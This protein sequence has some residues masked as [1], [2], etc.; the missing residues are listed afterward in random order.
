MEERKVIV[1]TAGTTVQHTITH[2]GKAWVFTTA[3]GNEAEYSTIS[4]MMQRHNGVDWNSSV[5]AHVED[6]AKP[7]SIDMRP[8]PLIERF[9]HSLGSYG[10]AQWWMEGE[11]VSFA[12]IKT[13]LQ[14]VLAENVALKAQQPKAPVR[15]LRE[16]KGV[17]YLDGFWVDADGCKWEGASGVIWNN[18]LRNPRQK[19]GELTDADFLAIYALKD[20]PYEPVETVEEVLR[21]MYGLFGVSMI[22]MPKYHEDVITR[23]RAAFAAE[24]G[25]AE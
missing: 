6:L 7:A 2:N 1:T 16:V 23:L 21:E 4:A 14:N 19:Q 11:E 15:K 18:N 5:L 25:G 24:Q 12:E 17:T 3:N 22:A 20:D 13:A 8:V 9:L 10:S